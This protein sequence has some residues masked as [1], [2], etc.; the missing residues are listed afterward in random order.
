[1]THLIVL[2]ER[3]RDQHGHFLPKGIKQ[4]VYACRHT[5]GKRGAPQKFRW[6]GRYAS[7]LKCQACQADLVISDEAKIY[8]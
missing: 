3:K 6:Y 7:G 2:D 1:M 8:K 4:P 5:N